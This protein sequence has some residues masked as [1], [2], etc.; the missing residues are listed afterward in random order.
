MACNI[1]LNMGCNSEIYICTHNHTFT[2][3]HKASC[4]CA[5]LTKNPVVFLPAAA[6]IFLQYYMES[7]P[8]PHDPALHLMWTRNIY[9]SRTLQ[10]I[11][12][13]PHSR[14]LT[15]EW[16]KQHPTPH[17]PHSLSGGLPGDWAGCCCPEVDEVCAG[18]LSVTP[19]PTC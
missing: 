14:V 12:S 3:T 17:P 13:P 8:P 11:T 2:P 10:P 4:Y 5:K 7:P 15:G 19:P 1:S 18:P 9:P 6:E 16:L